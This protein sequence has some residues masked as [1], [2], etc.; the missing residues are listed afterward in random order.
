[1][2]TLA[3]PVPPQQGTLAW[4]AIVRIRS[5][6][7]SPGWAVSLSLGNFPGG[8]NG[9][10]PIHSSDIGG[11]IFWIVV[12]AVWLLL[13]AYLLRAAA[14]FRNSAGTGKI[15]RANNPGQRRNGGKGATSAGPAAMLCL[16]SARPEASTWGRRSH[17]IEHLRREVTKTSPLVNGPRQSFLLRRALRLSFSFSTFCWAVTLPLSAQS[18]LACWTSAVFH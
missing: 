11:V 18:C 2:K 8:K 14:R 16:L 7:C 1:M 6:H 4:Q 10:A 15:A 13:I 5:A 12:L 3:K 17:L 9:H